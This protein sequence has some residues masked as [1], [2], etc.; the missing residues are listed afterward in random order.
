MRRT[1]VPLLSLAAAA[2]LA[3]PL[4]A[5]TSH[6]AAAGGMYETKRADMAVGIDQARAVRLP[7][8]A[9]LVAVG[10]PS[11]ADAIIQD[12]DM[13]L[14][15]GRSFGA[16]NVLVFGHDGAEIASYVVNV[17]DA[18]PRLVTLNRGAARYSYNC[19][20]HCERILKVGDEPE[21]AK[22][23]IEQT[24]GEQGLA[25]EGAEATA[26]GSLQ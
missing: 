18:S 22:A 24:G 10:N 4:A 15:V 16:T 3:L 25:T 5:G 2:L 26:S 11:I 8:A 21:S 9:G 20:P 14:L 1:D 23:V 19:A 7:G 17:V 12:S 13:L 6:P